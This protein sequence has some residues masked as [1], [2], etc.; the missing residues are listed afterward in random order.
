MTRP[1]TKAQMQQDGVSAELD[2]M[3]DLIEVVTSQMEEMRQRLPQQEAPAAAP[4]VGSDA[5]I[6]LVLQTCRIALRH[7]KALPA[8]PPVRNIITA[9]YKMACRELSAKP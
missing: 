2:V 6:R 5:S 9:A 7:A 8:T 3:Q 4:I 1:M